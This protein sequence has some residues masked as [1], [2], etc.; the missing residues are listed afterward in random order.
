MNKTLN[1]LL[2]AAVALTI[3]GASTD[4]FAG[5]DKK[6]KEKCYGASKAGKNDCASSDGRHSCAAQAEKDGDPTEWV[7]VPKGLCNK[8]VGGSLEGKK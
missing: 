7:Y 5:K 1:T 8:L 4:A 6:A 3:A 2:T